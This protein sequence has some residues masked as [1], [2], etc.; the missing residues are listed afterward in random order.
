MPLGAAGGAL[1]IR[2][3]PWLQHLITGDP[4]GPPIYMTV[5]VVVGFIALLGV[6]VDD[7]VVIGT[8]IQQRYERDKPTTRAEIR[9]VVIEAGSRR[10]R[11]ALMTTVTTV[12]ALVPVLLTTGRGS[13]VMQ[14]MALPIIG[15]MTIELLTLFVVPTA[16][17]LWLELK[18]HPAPE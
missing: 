16:M 11:P 14:P 9:R 1:M 7:G 2:Y 17:S 3:W 5:A 15:G 13:D 8:Y 10:I 4:Q 18:H 12:V 6:L